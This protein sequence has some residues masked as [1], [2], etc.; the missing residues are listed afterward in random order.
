MN[1]LEGKPCPFCGDGH[2][3]QQA[4]DTDYHYKGH[5]LLISQSGMYCDACDE[6]I[7]EP[8]D[9]K[10]TRLDLQ[11]F[12]SRVDGL[13]EPKQIRQIRKMLGLNQKVAGDIFGGGHNAFSRYE[14][15]ELAPPKALSLLLTVL[16]E[17]E[18]IRQEVLKPKRG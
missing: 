13:L 1:Q 10:S 8:D 2:L 4:R 17:H 11:A 7:L 15:G 14:R 3:H 18:A 16:A 5:T 9:L 12:R 6:A